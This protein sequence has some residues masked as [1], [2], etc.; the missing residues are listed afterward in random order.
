[1]TTHDVRPSLAET[2]MFD[3][4]EWM[5]R[6]RFSLGWILSRAA[7]LHRDRVAVRDLDT[8]R[9][10]T[11][12]ELDRAANRIGNTL[13]DRGVVKREI[14]ALID[15]NGVDLV[16]SMFG[17]MKAGA[18]VLPLSVRLLAD[19][20]E[21]LLTK[22]GV[23]RIVVGSGYAE[24]GLHVAGRVATVTDVLLHGEY[25]GDAP[26]ARLQV[27]TESDR[28]EISD[29]P[30][31][32]KVYLED[33]AIVATT[34][35]TTG[36][37]KLVLFSHVGVMFDVLTVMW[38]VGVP[39]AAVVLQLAPLYHMAGITWS[40][41]PALWS[42]GTLAFPARGPFD[43]EIVLDSIERVQASYCLLVPAMVTSLVD[44]SPEQADRASSLVTATCASAPLSEPL[45]RRF[46]ER[47]P[48]CALSIG[49][50]ISENLSMS[51]LAPD[52]LLSRPTSVG[53]PL[54]HNEAYVADAQTGEELPT[55]E[56]GE[57]VARNVTM[58]LEYVGEDAVEQRSMWRVPD[59][60]DRLFTFTGDLGVSD[61]DGLLT[62]VDRSKDMVL[63]GGLNVFC[64]EVEAALQSHPAVREVAVI[65]V[66]D[67]RWGE[68]VHAVVALHSGAQATEQEIRRWMEGRLG[69]YKRPKGYTFVDALPRNNFG[70]VLKREMRKWFTSTASSHASGDADA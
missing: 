20:M 58:G 59:G 15:A 54:I 30:P 2:R 44:V 14:V 46:Q 11:F 7:R 45:R 5:D 63:S 36:A 33:P 29:T 42:G 3:P 52:L 62:I 19:E 65:G 24:Q 49:Y 4:D 28:R 31:A 6:R 69:D 64:P 61:E 37:S 66:P 56:I 57:I 12:G 32:V 18:V 23:R 51:L 70:K 55:G 21:P 68:A 67:S 40:L 22:A 41:L 17:I 43:P 35:G 9:S 60:D 38:S 8:G 25:S 39:Q 16:A 13:L 50:G 10:M 26:R 48:H 47:F 53:E 1:M 27:I 34:G